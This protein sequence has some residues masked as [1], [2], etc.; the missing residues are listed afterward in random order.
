MGVA[1]RNGNVGCSALAPSPSIFYR[2]ARRLWVTARQHDAQCSTFFVLSSGGI[3]QAEPFHTAPDEH[4]AIVHGL[5]GVGISGSDRNHPII[6]EG[7]YT[8][9]RKLVRCVAVPEPS[10]HSV[11]SPRVELACCDDGA[12][13][14]ITS[15]HGAC[16]LCCVCVCV[17]AV[18]RT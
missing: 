18:L 10:I 12:A 17:S 4:A 7:L 8:L 1:K 2:D 3:R 14:L 5:N 16:A 13:G 15:G 9:R 11:A 6:S